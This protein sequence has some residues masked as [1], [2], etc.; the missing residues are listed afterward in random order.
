MSLPPIRLHPS[1]LVLGGGFVAWQLLTG[2][3]GA[4]LIALLFGLAV[5]GSVALHELGHALMAHRFGIRTRNIT[6]YPFGGI[7]AL[8]REPRGHA[9]LW[10]ALAGP[11]V[12]FG[13]A[14]I[15]LP[16]L[17]MVPGASLFAAINLGMGVFNLLPAFPM[18]GGRVVR[19]WWSRDQGHV[20]ATERALGV[21]RWF[22]WGFIALAVLSGAWNLALVGAFLLWVVG[23]E[24]RRLRSEQWASRRSWHV[25]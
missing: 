21:S 13:L 22:A 25:V 12:N 14:L 10:I 6:L 11:L 2:G 1:F 9:E 23:A 7:A 8:E 18:D 5:F 16:L 20:R 24:R 17:G 15:T 4:A 19:A 3:F